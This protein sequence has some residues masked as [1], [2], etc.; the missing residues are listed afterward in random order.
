MKAITTGTTPSTHKTNHP[1]SDQQT[2]TK[3]D[4]TAPL[5]QVL[6]RLV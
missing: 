5:L 3:I 6:R 1:P 4:I 2:P